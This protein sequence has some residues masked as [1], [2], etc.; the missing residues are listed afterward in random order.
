MYYQ[1][2]GLSEA[3]FS[4]AVNPRYLFM[5]ARH[6][7]ALAHLL[8]G[9]GAGGGFILLTGEVGTGKTTINRC[10]LEQLPQNTDVAIVLNPALNAMELLATVCD[11]LGVGYDQAHPT[12]K[13]LTDNLHRYL[14]DNHQRGRRTVL[15]IDEAQHLDF[16]VLE[17]IRLLTNLETNSEKLLQ[18]I[19]IGQPE[20]AQ[21]LARPELR[22]LNQRITARYDLQPLNRLETAAYIRHR[23]Q[24]AGLPPGRELFPRRVIS[25]IFRH[26]RGI[27]RL[28][29]V[30]CDRMLLGAY[31]R[32]RPCVDL[33]IFRQAR[34]EVMGRDAA[35]RRRWWPVLV[36]I[37]VLFSAAVLWW[38][39]GA[40]WGVVKPQTRAL[41]SAPV[42]PESSA[43]RPL[44]E[45]AATPV[46]VAG[47]AGDPVHQPAMMPGAT[48]AV[49]AAVFAA[50][51]A[52]LDH[53][54]VIDGIFLA[55]EIAVSLLWQLYADVPLA[56]LACGTAINGGVACVQ[57]QARTWDELADLD[58][59]LLLDVVTPG[60]FA[61][62]VLLLGVDGQRGWVWTGQRVA[63]IDLAQLAPFWTGNYRFYWH[64]PPHFEHPLARGDVSA[65]VAAVAQLFAQLDGQAQALTDRRFNTDLQQ[66]VR[67]FQRTQGLDDDGVVGLQTLLRLNTLLGVDPSAKIARERLQAQSLAGAAG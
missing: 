28:I 10:L 8:Y 41:A 31:G 32:D 7:D 22:Q 65:T 44:A 12:L 51:T 6:R 54:A 25:A 24:V 40:G 46:T 35:L 37:T 55:P 57:G 4:I 56:G 45:S 64:P 20:L 61:A 62:Q 27:P 21:I 13:T 3:P 53:T 1:Y 11:E 26:T 67:L 14:L 59:P 16:D 43:V 18:I 23:L 17:Q 15:M 36:V 42:L 33:S 39:A 2:F 34:D 30:L 29:N 5:S 48:A 66:R 63:A 49:N 19:L 58:R 60:R 52:A 47:M 9:V 50:P 38:Q